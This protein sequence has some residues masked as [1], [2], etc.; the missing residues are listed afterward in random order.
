MP[1][2][3]FLS[4]VLALSS[5]ASSGSAV[6]GMHQPLWVQDPY[7]RYNRLEYFAVVGSGYTRQDAERNALSGLIAQFGQTIKVDTKVST[8]YLEIIRGDAVNWS[9]VTNS[10]IIIA[11]SSGMDNLVGAEIGEAWLDK[12]GTHYVAAIL[13]KS[14][15]AR[16]YND[17][18]KANL[19]IIDRL[20]NI[21]AL[22][23]NSLNGH[24]RFLYAASIADMTVAY[25]NL[26]QQ[27][28]MPV[29]EIERGDQY[30]LEA[31]N[32]LNAIPVSIR[33]QNDKSG[34]IEAAFAKVFHSLGFQ[35]GG[36]NLRYLLE[37]DISIESLEYPGNLH[38]F[39]RFELKANFIDTCLKKLL[40]PYNFIVR[41]GH[42]TQIEADNRAYL[43]AERKIEEEYTMLLNDLLFSVMLQKPVKTNGA[44][45]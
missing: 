8:T 10:E 33:V 9:E 32:I 5:C 7:T 30:R 4:L 31:L 13:N 6:T 2:I 35:S 15:A 37:V 23:K 38:K 21:S 40:L 20:T 34:I 25:G 16:E 44:L 43:A 27:L 26:L 1:I 24:T 14:R 17:I 18:V 19:S 42:I 29:Q 28:G 12:S 39:A 11:L 3:C 36:N 22:E 41:Q 45:F